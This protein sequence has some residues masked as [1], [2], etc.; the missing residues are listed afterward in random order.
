MCTAIL[1]RLRS[2][3]LRRLIAL[4]AVCAVFGAGVAQAA[5]YHKNESARGFDTHVQCLLCMHADR[6]AGPPELP[7]YA[8]PVFT[9][10]VAVTLLIAARA[11]RSPAIFYHAR[12]P[13]LI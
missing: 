13:P 1:Q 4:L 10:S 12:G 11:R 9:L 7:R 6:S 3:R 2:W 5:H 8:P